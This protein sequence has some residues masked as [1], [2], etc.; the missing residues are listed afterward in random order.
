VIRSEW[1]IASGFVDKHEG[2][3]GP[4]LLWSASFVARDEGIQYV[5]ADRQ[6]FSTGPPNFSRPLSR[7]TTIKK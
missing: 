5:R 7:R 6:A 3:R 1:L 2:Q 4:P